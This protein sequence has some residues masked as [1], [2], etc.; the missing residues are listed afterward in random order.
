MSSN[1]AKVTKEKPF[2]ETLEYFKFNFVLKPRHLLWI[3]MGV[4]LVYQRIQ[5][6]ISYNEA[7]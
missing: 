1:K 7:R 5:D 4:Y 6:S 3:S 2:V